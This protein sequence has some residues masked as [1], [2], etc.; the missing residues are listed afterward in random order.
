MTKPILPRLG[1]ACGAAFAIVLFV[2]VG[3]GS[4]GFSA[5]RAVAGVAAITLAIP[6]IC[7]LGARLR[8][9]EGASGWLSV[10]A[11]GAGLT[12]IT[13]KLSSGAP[14]LAEHRAGVPPTGQLHQALDGIG[15]GLTVMSLSRSS[16]P[17]PRS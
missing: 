7:Y 10:T 9:A 6:F 5:P 4:H 15:G 17:R 14:E 13:L 16:A 12:G 2:A 3:D 8:A 1:A 11:V